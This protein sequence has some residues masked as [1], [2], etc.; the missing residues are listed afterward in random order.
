[1]KSV[2]E[3]NATELRSAL[4]RCAD[5]T[6][7]QAGL[8]QIRDYLALRELSPMAAE[9]LLQRARVSLAHARAYK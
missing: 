1:M 8:A 4:G 3:M 5:C 6:H 2:Y 7:K 9:Y